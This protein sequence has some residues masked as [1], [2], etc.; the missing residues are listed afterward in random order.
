VLDKLKKN[1]KAAIVLANGSLSTISKGEKEIRI[2][3][4]KYNKIDTIIALPPS[5][6]Y[7]TGIPASI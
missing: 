7:T 2:N 6:F 1:G 4:L 3:F 5:L